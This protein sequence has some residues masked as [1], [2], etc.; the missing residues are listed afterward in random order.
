MARIYVSVGTV[1]LVWRMGDKRDT[2]FVY[3][4]P[5]LPAE[6]DD[7]F[8]ILMERA[9]DQ[10]GNMFSRLL[11]KKDIDLFAAQ[12][13]MSI[14]HGEAGG[15]FD[16][17]LMRTVNYGAARVV[18]YTCFYEVNSNNLF[19]NNVILGPYSRVAPRV[20]APLY[21]IATICAEPE[22][23]QLKYSGSSIL[24]LRFLMR[25]SPPYLISD[26][27]LM[28]HPAEGLQHRLVD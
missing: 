19:E 23:N 13:I 3:V 18:V 26:Y 10:D 6:R 21:D 25:Q 9:A 17:R 1:P 11:F 28:G 16:R 2:Y 5:A 20:I 7:K 24:V 4:W 27:P 22:D 8:G 14:L 15:V 12:G